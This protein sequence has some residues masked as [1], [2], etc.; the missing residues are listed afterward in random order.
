MSY[1]GKMKKCVVCRIALCFLSGSFACSDAFA[2]SY[3]L[4]DFLFGKQT[5]DERK[6]EE[7]QGR[8]NQKWGQRQQIQ[9]VE[10]A[11]DDLEEN[12]VEHRAN[13]HAENKTEEPQPEPK[14]IPEIS[15]DASINEPIEI[16]EKEIYVSPSMKVNSVN[17]LLETVTQNIKCIEKGRMS[18][19]DR[20]NLQKE[21]ELIAKNIEQFQNTQSIYG[22]VHLFEVILKSYNIIN[23]IPVRFLMDISKDDISKVQITLLADSLKAN[24]ENLAKDFKT[25]LSE[26][27]NNKISELIGIDV[28]QNLNTFA[29]SLLEKVK[30]IPT[31]LLDNNAGKRV[32]EIVKVFNTQIGGDFAEKQ[33]V[34]LNMFNAYNALKEIS[35]RLCRIDNEIIKNLAIKITEDLF[36]KIKSD[37]NIMKR[38]NYSV[39]ADEDVIALAARNIQKLEAMLFG[40]QMASG[41]SVDSRIEK[42]KKTDLINGKKEILKEVVGQFNK[43]AKYCNEALALLQSKGKTGENVGDIALI[44]EDIDK[45]FAKISEYDKPYATSSNNFESQ[46]S[47]DDATIEQVQEEKISEGVSVDPQLKKAPAETMTITPEKTSKFSEVQGDSINIGDLESAE[48]EETE[49]AEDEEA[50]N[51]E[52]ELAEIAESSNEE[53]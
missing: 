20:S 38:A 22:R 50:K 6:S 15:Q 29:A 3:S 31:E 48:D 32:E 4:T 46:E 12:L 47:S 21:N 52:E 19:S 30:S 37:L 8:I 41:T 1:G 53:E 34:M 35:F 33:S 51:I 24:Q 27:D 13:R 40:G 17:E 25:A 39:N 36:M 10:E 42:F 28:L 7:S 26:Q 9:N 18:D 43:T 45:I 2:E 16:N 14:S 5:V 11:E 44:S 23:E 49:N